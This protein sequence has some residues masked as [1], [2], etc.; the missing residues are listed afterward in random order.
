M[1]L[2]IFYLMQGAPFPLLKSVPFFNRANIEEEKL[3]RQ[4]IF[5]FTWRWAWFYL[6]NTRV[7]S[8][9]KLVFPLVKR[10]GWEQPLRILCGWG[11]YCMERTEHGVRHGM[12]GLGSRH[13]PLSL[14]APDMPQTSSHA[15]PPRTSHVSLPVTLGTHAPHSHTRISTSASADTHT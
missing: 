7:I 13:L 11:S 10:H 2:L 4:R 6:C 14:L 12:N 3:C 8:L 5:E 15:S 9:F 1:P